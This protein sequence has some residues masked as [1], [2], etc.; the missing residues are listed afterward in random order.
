MS[1]LYPAPGE[2]VAV[3]TRGQLKRLQACEAGMA[4]FDSFLVKKE[5]RR[6][7]AKKKNRLEVIWSPLAYLWFMD[8]YRDFLIWLYRNRMLSMPCF[9]GL[10]LTEQDLSYYD[11]SGAD[12]RDVV[13]SKSRMIWG[14]FHRVNL[15]NALMLHV[16]TCGSDFSRSVLYGADMHNSSF[17]HTRFTYAD[18]SSAD[19]RYSD[20]RSTHLV[21][22]NLSGASIE[23]TDFTAAYRSEY[24]PP[25]PGWVV[26]NGHLERKKEKAA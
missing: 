22:A 17:I 10:D 7:G 9:R 8:E 19:L 11:L 14:I 1:K 2:Q 23:G 4:L 26:V 6:R 21:G 20:F 5:S 12:M 18:L 3:I 16:A 15:T 25:I 13:L 24:D